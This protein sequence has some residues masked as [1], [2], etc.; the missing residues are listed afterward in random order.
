MEPAASRQYAGTD[1]RDDRAVHA[2]D[3]RAG[4]RADQ[5][6]CDLVRRDEK[7]GLSRTQAEYRP[8]E[9]K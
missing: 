2:V 9:Q 6:A 4:E 8:G 1:P 5:E 3:N 7:S